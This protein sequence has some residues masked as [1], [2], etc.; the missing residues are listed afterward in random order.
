MVNNGNS[1]ATEIFK[2]NPL[3]AIQ[4]D[5]DLSKIEDNSTLNSIISHEAIVINEKH[6][7][8]YPLAINCFLFMGSNRPV[9]IQEAKSGLIRRLIDVLPSGRKVSSKEYDALVKKY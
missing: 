5:G 3:V 9:K 1:F 4:H 7:S 8:Q 6:K 2:T